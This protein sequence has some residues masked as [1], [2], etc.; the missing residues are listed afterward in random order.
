MSDHPIIPFE[1]IEAGSRARIAAFL[2]EAIGKALE[3]YYAFVAQ[4]VSDD[5]KAFS[6]H[7]SAGKVAIAHIELLLK[8]ARFVD[9]PTRQERELRA[10]LAMEAAMNRDAENAVSAMLHHFNSSDAAGEN[11]DEAE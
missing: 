5:V 2:P 10:Q 4:E 3:S 8:L 1:S 7:H 9:L 11:E 6:A